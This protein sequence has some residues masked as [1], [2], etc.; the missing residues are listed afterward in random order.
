MFQQQADFVVHLFS[1]KIDS[2]SVS[3]RLCIAASYDIDLIKNHK[4]EIFILQYSF[5]S[6]FFVSFYVSGILKSNC[7]KWII[8]IFNYN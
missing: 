3:T 4:N 8:F 6:P 7:K 2:V 5:Y 1:Y